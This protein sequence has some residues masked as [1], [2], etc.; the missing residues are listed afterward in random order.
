MDRKG[1]KESKL[2]AQEILNKW[3]LC[4]TCRVAIV[5]T[6]VFPHDLRQ[7]VVNERT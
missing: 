6:D 2:T 4:Y 1:H 5:A 7:F 3:L